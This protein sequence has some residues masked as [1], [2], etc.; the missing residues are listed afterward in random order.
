M[1]PTHILTTLTSMS[2]VGVVETCPY[3]NVTE[4]FRYKNNDPIF[5]FVKIMVDIWVY[6]ISKSGKPFN[7]GK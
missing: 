7:F 1:S 2:T 4:T 5:V 3:A 6:S